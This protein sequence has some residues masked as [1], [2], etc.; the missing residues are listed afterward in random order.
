MDRDNRWERVSAAYD[1]MVLAK[2]VAPTVD[3]PLAALQQ[4]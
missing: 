4:G 1:V 2:G 3:E